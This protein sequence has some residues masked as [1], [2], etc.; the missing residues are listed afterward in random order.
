MDRTPSSHS[1]A[2]ILSAH[3]ADE[4]LIVPV[5]NAVGM[6][7]PGKLEK[8]RKTRLRYRISGDVD[9][10]RNRKWP[11]AFAAETRLRVRNYVE[12]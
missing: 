3:A 8:E 7:I 4:K 1:S 2:V 9:T 6:I 11:P 10:S 5:A 12:V